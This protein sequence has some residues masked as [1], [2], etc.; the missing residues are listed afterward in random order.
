MEERSIRKQ[1]IGEN[2]KQ[3][4][5]SN[6]RLKVDEGNERIARNREK[7]MSGGNREKKE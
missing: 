5:K 2:Q 4:T 6:I 1:K 7:G 3:K